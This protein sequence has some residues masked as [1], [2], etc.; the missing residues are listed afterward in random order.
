MNQHPESNPKQ[1]L[2]TSMFHDYINVNL[3][4]A[5]EQWQQAQ[6]S[7]YNLNTTLSSDQPA[8]PSLMYPIIDSQ[9]LAS[10]IAQMMTQI[11][12]QQ[13]LPPFS[14]INLLS[15]LSQAT[16]FVIHWFKKLSDIT[17]YDKNRDCLNVWK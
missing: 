15:L 12:T 14:I 5:Y 8:P 6:Q 9:T 2:N 11:I 1:K 3:S 17:E 4:A 16:A 13:P 7:H 10:I